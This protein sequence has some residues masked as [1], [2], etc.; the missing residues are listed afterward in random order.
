MKAVVYSRYGGPDQLQFA[1]IDLPEPAKG[2][3]RVKVL[4]CAVNLS[5]WEYL[6]GAPAWVRTVGGLFK[7]KVPVLGSDIVGIVDKLG[8]G[9][10]G[11]EIGQRVMGDY[12]MTRGGFAEYACVP[13]DETVAVPDALSDEIAACIPQAGGIAVAGTDGLSDGDRMLI[14]GAGGGSGTM[15]MQLA[16][17]AGVHVTAVDNAGK[18]EWLESLGADKVID[19][20][21]VNFTETGERWDRILDMVATRGPREISQALAEGGAYMALGGDVPTLLSIVFGGK[22]LSRNRSIGMLLVPSGQD[23]TRRAAELALQGRIVPHIDAVLPFAA[24]PEAL[25][26][27]GKGK[28]LGKIV[29]KPEL[30]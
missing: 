27:T 25:A 17:A 10:S 12:V 19:Y 29:I 6:T 13:S 5:D 9:V 7:P 28:V 21:T 14:N 16:K 3:I 11:F 22:L 1:D 8:E 2:E 15:A 23:L 24:V 26:R 30:A 20:A 4:A 18:T